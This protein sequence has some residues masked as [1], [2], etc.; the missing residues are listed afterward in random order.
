MKNSDFSFFWSVVFPALILVF[1]V[2]VTVW[3]YRLFSRKPEGH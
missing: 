1:S 3:L 2:W